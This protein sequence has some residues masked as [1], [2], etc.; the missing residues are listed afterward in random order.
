M[1]GFFARNRPADVRGIGPQAAL[2]CA[3]IHA[4]AFPHPWSS[5]EFE[6]LLAGRDVVADAAMVKSWGRLLFAGFVLSRI[7]AGEAEILTIAVGMKFRR[8][9]I[10]SALLA[11][12]LASL[13]AKGTK[14]LFLEVEAGNHAALALYKSFG[15][16]QVGERKAYYRKP[17]AANAAALV[18]RLDFA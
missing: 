4:E 8:R 18:L 7:V 11:A 13:A 14:I 10:G 17:G 9:G 5:S 2:A 1:F 3:A 16:R 15:F 12:H 6:A